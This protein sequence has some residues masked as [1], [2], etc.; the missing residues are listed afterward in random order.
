MS[1][2]LVADPKLELLLLGLTNAI[3]ELKNV[4]AE[5]R[6][7][8]L[9]VSPDTCEMCGGFGVTHHADCDCRTMGD[10]RRSEPIEAA[11]RAGR[12]A[13]GHIWNVCILCAGDGVRKKR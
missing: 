12:L 1:V 10:V 5:H 13:D 7:P 2:H 6:R 11:R 8:L 4:V 3:T 9:V